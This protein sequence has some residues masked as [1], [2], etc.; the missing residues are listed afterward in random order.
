MP[1]LRL[2]K[3][4]S[5]FQDSPNIKFSPTHHFIVP[6]MS[7][8]ALER[9]DESL[10]PILAQALWSW[11]LCLTCQSGQQCTA[12]CCPLRRVGRLRR[13]LQFYKGV[14]STYVG[15]AD[16]QSSRV[17]QTHGDVCC[18][19]GNLK[20]QPDISKAKFQEIAFHRRDGGAPYEPD[21]LLNATSLVVKV[22]MMIES[23]ALHRSSDRLEMGTFRIAWKDE[24]SFSKYI[25]DLFPLGHHPVLSSTDRDL[26][27]D[28]RLA[29]RATN[30][31]RL[32]ISFQATH[33]VRNHLRLDRKNRVLELFHHTA[34]LKEHL[35]ATKG[36]GDWSNPTHSTRVYKTSTTYCRFPKS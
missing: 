20:S 2:F 29:L 33:D 11:E 30:L 22:L 16:N 1:R 19:I 5:E 10:L 7:T 13:Y 9:F 36:E 24:V 28:M 25:Q 18:A 35:R 4:V 23:S 6:S 15:M 12:E 32:G 27:L 21:D 31:A 26:S 34:F 3:F 17:L 8:L 14:V